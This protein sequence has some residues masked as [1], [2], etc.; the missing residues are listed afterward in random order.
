MKELGVIQIE[1]TSLVLSG[2]FR[3]RVGSSLGRGILFQR[4]TQPLSH[5]RLGVWDRLEVAETATGKADRARMGKFQTV[6]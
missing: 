1:G 6:L 3:S 5:S 2:T 4:C